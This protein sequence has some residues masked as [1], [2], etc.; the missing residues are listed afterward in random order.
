MIISEE[1]LVTAS[2]TCA[3]SK[4]DSERS[5]GSVTIKQ[6]PNDNSTS[7]TEDCPK[8]NNCYSLWEYNP[9]DPTNA[10]LYKILGKG[11]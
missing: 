9:S 3:Y 2:L 5:V 6:S 11:L 8:G 4:P 10:S 7:E 1:E